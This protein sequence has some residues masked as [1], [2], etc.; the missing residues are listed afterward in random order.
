MKTGF[1]REIVFALFIFFFLG[2]LHAQ[3]SRTDLIPPGTIHLKNKIFI[4]KTPVTNLMFLEYLAFKGLAADLGYNTFQEYL[5]SRKVGEFPIKPIIAYP[6]VVLEGYSKDV[7][8]K[9]KGYFSE[10]EYASY[11]V[12][13]LS[14][15]DA[16]DFCSWRTAMVAHL[17]KNEN[18]RFSNLQYRLATIAQLNFAKRKYQSI[19]KAEPSRKKLSNYHLPKKPESFMVL[20]IH[21]YSLD[22]VVFQSQLKAAYT[23]FRCVCELD[24][25]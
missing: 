6:N 10:T 5:N 4:D 17:Y 3:N 18:I 20:P 13:N 16:R 24:S 12:L 9:R 22:S 7:F 19:V 11:A 25:E 14:I 23:G 2:K 21:E 8:L 15:K 1:I